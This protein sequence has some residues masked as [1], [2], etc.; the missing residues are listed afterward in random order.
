M[1]LLRFSIDFPSLWYHLTTTGCFIS[2]HN[3][4]YFT[5]IFFMVT[6]L[7][8][9][10]SAYM[11]WAD[12]F[13]MLF[14]QI[15]RSKNRWR[16][17]LKDGIMNINQ[18]DYVFHKAHGEAEWWR[19][20]ICKALSAIVIARG[21]VPIPRHVHWSDKSP[22]CCIRRLRILEFTVHSGR[23]YYLPTKMVLVYSF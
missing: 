8:W 5:E 3:T 13:T 22:A 18:R 14:K 7:L 23:V 19:S 4:P 2:I 17:T 16:F 6:D 11:H 15:T 21:P 20:T 9:E 12:N 1:T 10:L